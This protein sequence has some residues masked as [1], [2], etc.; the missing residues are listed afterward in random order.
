MDHN[1]NLEEMLE[2]IV[3]DKA[4]L[5]EL[6]DFINKISTGEASLKELG[7]KIIELRARIFNALLKFIPYHQRLTFTSDQGENNTP[8]IQQELLEKDELLD[9]IGS[10]INNSYEKLKNEL[11]SSN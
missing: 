7:K 1:D 9:Q 10:K 2:N 8:E 4:N 11:E 5:S 3:F 6:K